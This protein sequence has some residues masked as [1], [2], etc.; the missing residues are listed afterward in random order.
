MSKK[1]ADYFQDTILTI[2]ESFVN[3]KTGETKAI[4]SKVQEQVAYHAKNNTLNHLVFSALHDYLHH[5]KPVQVNRQSE[6]AILD[7][8]L[9]LKRLLL[10]NGNDSSKSLN[11]CT[12]KSPK[13]LDHTSVGMK[14]IDDLLEAFGG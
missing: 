4:T 10:P 8:L 5:S 14:E 1:Y 13:E 6:S 2:P 9:E 11:E 12:I 7:E 3:V